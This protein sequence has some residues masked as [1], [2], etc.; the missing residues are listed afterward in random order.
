MLNVVEPS[1]DIDWL[2]SD[3]SDGDDDR[4]TEPAAAAA[5]APAAGGVSDADDV[6]CIDEDDSPAV[7]A[8]LVSTRPPAYSPSHVRS[9]S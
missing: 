5:A 9:V 4:E 2:S 7:T 1:G 8:R 3:E 6:L